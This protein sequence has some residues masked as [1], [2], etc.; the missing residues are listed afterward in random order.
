[1]CKKF[2]LS[3]GQLFWSWEICALLVE[4]AVHVIVGFL[5][6]AKADRFSRVESCAPQHTQGNDAVLFLR[7]SY[8]ASSSNWNKLRRCF[9]ESSVEICKRCSVEFFHFISRIK[10]Y[11]RI[12][13]AGELLADG[14]WCMC[15]VT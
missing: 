3:H 13:V 10:F 9:Y 2:L 5:G 7:K 6:R 11:I 15:I 8:T 12:D 1:M 14:N 4:T